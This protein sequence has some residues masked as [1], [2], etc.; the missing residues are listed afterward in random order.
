MKKVMIDESHRI[1][2]F[3]QYTAVFKCGCAYVN[4]SWAN[5]TQCDSVC[6]EHLQVR[7]FT[8]SANVAGKR[9]E[10]AESKKSPLKVPPETIARLK[11]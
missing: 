1:P 5:E 7:E 4:D 9:P 8:A 11:G 3:I 2:S 6:P 10:N